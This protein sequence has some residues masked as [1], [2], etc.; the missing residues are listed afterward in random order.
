MTTNEQLREEFYAY[1]GFDYNSD[2][3]GQDMTNRAIKDS[4][5]YWLAKL[6]EVK[7]EAVEGE[8]ERITKWAQ[9]RFCNFKIE[10]DAADVNMFRERMLVPPELTVEDGYKHALSDLNNFLHPHSKD[11]IINK[12]K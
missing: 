6:E 9:E 5:D 3:E 12:E 8:R 4:A 7:K 10:L 2:S 11:E 1:A